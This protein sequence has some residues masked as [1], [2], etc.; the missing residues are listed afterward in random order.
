MAC[1]TEKGHFQVQG[2]PGTQCHKDPLHLVF[3]LLP[4]QMAS[5]LMMA[6][7]PHQPQVYL[8]LRWET[9]LP[10]I[11]PVWVMYPS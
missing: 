10:L 1:I 8:L 11:G 4:S 7:G 6:N 3:V 2:D 5:P 9:C